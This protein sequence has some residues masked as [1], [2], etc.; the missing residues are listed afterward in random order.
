MENIVQK[1]QNAGL[2]VFSSFPT[3]FFS[4]HFFNVIKSWDCVSKS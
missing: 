1:E 3:M 2:Q 4:K